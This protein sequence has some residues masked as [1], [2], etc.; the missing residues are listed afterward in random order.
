MISVYRGEI[1]MIFS[2]YSNQPPNKKIEGFGLYAEV[3][4]SPLYGKDYTEKTSVNQPV[5]GYGV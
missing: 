4:F 1:L 3:H 5:H 2:G